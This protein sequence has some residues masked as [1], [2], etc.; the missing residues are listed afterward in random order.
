MRRLFSERHNFGGPD[1]E[2]TIREDAPEFLRIGILRVCPGTSYRIAE[3]SQ[4]EPD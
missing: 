2:I 3:L 1:P 4:H